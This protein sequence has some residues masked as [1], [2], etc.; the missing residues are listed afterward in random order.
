MP[1]YEYACQHCGKTLEAL[2]KMQDPPL[3]DCTF[4]GQSA[5]T[6][7]I[8]KTSFQLKGSGWYATDFRDKSPTASGDKQDEKK[9]GEN[10]KPEV[11]CENEA[12]AATVPSTDKGVANAAETSD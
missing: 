5:L 11:K 4:C 3:T 12:A 8:S 6:K 9:P 2:Q 7:L 1:I 10:A